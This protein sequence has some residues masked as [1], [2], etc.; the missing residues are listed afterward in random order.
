VHYP[1][2]VHLQKAYAPLGYGRGAFPVS[3]IIADEFLSLPMY[4]DLNNDQID[5]VIEA[6]T[7]AVG[8]G[9]TV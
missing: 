7:E 3:E 1:V 2:P 8:A 4:P 6:V 9:V 5:Y